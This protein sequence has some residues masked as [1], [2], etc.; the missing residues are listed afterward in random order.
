MA[1]KK[2]PKEYQFKKGQSGNP[3]G[4]PK[5]TLKAFVRNEFREMSDEEKRK[6]LKKISPETQWKMGEGNPE[7]EVENK[8]SGEIIIKQIQ[9]GVPEQKES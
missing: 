9:Y 8:H 4:R 6:F 5:D 3:K 1:Y 7:S 2:P